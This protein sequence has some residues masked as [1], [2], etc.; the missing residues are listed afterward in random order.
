[1][2]KIQIL[3]LIAKSVMFIIISGL[4]LFM[5]FMLMVFIIID[6]ALVQN[7]VS[8]NIIWLLIP[9]IGIM[10]IMVLWIVRMLIETVPINLKV[11]RLVK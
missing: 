1:M 5:L 9:L 11:K 2:D 6:S 3:N 8:N 4:W 10:L 7:T